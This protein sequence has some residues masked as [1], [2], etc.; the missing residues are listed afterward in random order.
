MLLRG[1]EIA[2]AWN[3]AAVGEIVRL[4]PANAGVYRAWAS[5]SSQQ[6]F[7]LLRRKI[8]DPHPDTQIASKI[9]PV[10]ALNGGA[11]GDETEL[12]TRIDE[13]PLDTGAPDIG[14]ELRKLLDST[15]IE[16]M[17]DIA[18]SRAQT[19]GVFIGT[20]SGV[21]LLASADWDAAAV[22]D[23]VSAGLGKLLTTDQ[24]GVHWV[25]RRESYSEL[26]GLHPLALAT[27]GRILAIA[28]SKDLLTAM[29]AGL[30][31]AAFHLG[32]ALRRRL[33]SWERATELHS[34][35]A[36]DR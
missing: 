12:E 30:D 35:D 16:A 19:D 29:L 6:A 17:L 21:V 34:D 25:D 36:A 28:T 13:P 27:R 26:D 14:G 31:A 1:A 5:P 33:S 11:V 8:L 24:L 7:Q 10:V 15:Q 22:R 32:R 4:A 20:E 2:P 3:E 9:A 18:S 23:A